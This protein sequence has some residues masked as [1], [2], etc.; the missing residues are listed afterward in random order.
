MA[1][2]WTAALCAALFFPRAQAPETTIKTPAVQI[3]LLHEEAPPVPPP[4]VPPPPPRPV[5]HR[6]APAPAVVPAP[7]QNVPVVQD[8]QPPTAALSMGEPDP[9]APSEALSAASI[10]A[11]YAATLRTNI[12]SRTTVPSTPEYRLLKPQGS[13]RVSFTLERDGST[14]KVSLAHGSGSNLLDRQALSI[15]QSG[16]YPPFPEHAFPGE[17]RHI[18]VVTIEFHS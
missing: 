15:V 4:A 14:D 1:L 7:I 16:R 3:S 18:F 6:R 2:L 12:D 10:E 5:V 11:Q 17:A 13:T 9:P 8:T